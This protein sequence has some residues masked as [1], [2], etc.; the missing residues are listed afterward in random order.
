MTERHVFENQRSDDG[1]RRYAEPTRTAT[2]RWSSK[3]TSHG[4]E[5][6]RAVVLAGATP[7][8]PG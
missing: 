8:A 4:N 1:S 7:V 5:V 3:S 6:I 2:A